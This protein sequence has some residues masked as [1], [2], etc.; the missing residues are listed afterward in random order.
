MKSNLLT[1]AYVV[2]TMALFFFSFFMIAWA[3][4]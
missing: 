2:L 4:W 1:A 3:K